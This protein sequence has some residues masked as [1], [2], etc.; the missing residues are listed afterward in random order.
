MSTE[1][2]GAC[3]RRVAACARHWPCLCRGGAR[4]NAGG[5]RRRFDQPRRA[6]DIGLIRFG[7][8]W[9]GINLFKS[10]QGA[11]RPESGAYDPRDGEYTVI[12]TG[13]RQP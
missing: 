9:S 5:E 13:N 7:G 12:Y 11:K 1:E 10:G 4:R 3:H 2:N 6:A 8:D